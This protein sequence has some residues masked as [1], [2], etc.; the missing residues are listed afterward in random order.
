[1]DSAVGFEKCDAIALITLEHP[2][3]NALNQAIRR[4]LIETLST[5]LRDESVEALLLIGKGRQFSAGAD[6]GE[7]GDATRPP[8]HLREVIRAFDAS[9]KPIVAALHGVALG[10]ALELAMACHYRVS[11]P[12]ARL[13]LSEVK[14]G[15][16]PG[17]GGTQLLP[18]LIGPASA[19]GDDHDGRAR[20]SARGGQDGPRRSTDRRRS[21]GGRLGLRSAGRRPTAAAPHESTE[22]SALRP[23]GL[24]EA[25]DADVGRRAR[26][27]QAPQLAVAAVRAAVELPFDQGIERERELW[28]QAAA[29]PESAAMRYVFR[30]ERA[31]GKIADLSDDTARGE[32]RSV[33]VIGTGTMGTGI[34]IAFANAGFDVVLVGR[35]PDRV[36]AA[37]ASVG[38]HYSAAVE[39]GKLTEADMEARRARILPTTDWDALARVDLAIE[40]VL[41]DLGL[42]RKIFAKLDAACDGEAIFATNTSSLR[43]DVIANATRTPSRVIGLHFFSPAHAAKL[44]EIVCGEATG[45]AAMATGVNL[46]KRLGKFAVVVR[47]GDGLVSTRMFNRYQRVANRLLL[48]G[49]LPHEVDAA[50]VRF[51]MAVGPFAT[52]DLADGMS[53]PDPEAEAL[54]VAASKALGLQRRP[55]GDAE[56]VARCTAAMVKAGA[57]CLAEGLASRASD[58][59]VIWVDAYGFPRHRGGPMYHAGQ[60]DKVAA[61]HA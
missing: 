7:F 51:G 28:A 33:G 4:A 39:K 10:G 6:I 9:D 8:P 40:T 52:A 44:V 47:A 16:I 18:R 50:L 61:N 56:I 59:D 19:L 60:V 35:R 54:I 13:G 53:I 2:P 15:I 25:A 24:F 17:A 21:V 34:A 26:G 32:I 23:P 55:V 31:T 27:A 1:M 42:K 30:A 37:M 36:E 3:V 46:V 12:D 14:F 22:R 5:A 58:V 57:M 45:S 20:R 11:A 38:R 49:A 43:V 29:S 41:E 48:E